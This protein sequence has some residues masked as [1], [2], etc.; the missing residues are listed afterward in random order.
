M[1]LIALDNNTYLTAALGYAK[2]GMVTKALTLLGKC[3]S[4]EGRINRIVLLLLRGDFSI[5]NSELATCI[6]QYGKTHN[7]C[8]DIHKIVSSYDS[9]SLAHVTLNMPV[10]PAKTK[11]NIDEEYI[12]VINQ[13]ELEPLS[14]IFE[15]EID[16]FEL[17][18]M[19]N[20][21]RMFDI[22]S[23]EYL[24]FLKYKAYLLYAEG[25]QDEAN[26]L[27]E[28]IL[29]SD[30]DDI[31]IL[32]WKIMVLSNVR[33]YDK[34]MNIA[35]KIYDKI[36]DISHLGYIA[37]CIREGCGNKDML[38]SVIDKIILNLEQCS[39]D[40]VVTLM[41]ICND[42]LVD[43]SLA[44]IFAK[45]LVENYQYFPIDSMRDA[46][47]AFVNHG[48]IDS[49]K[50]VTTALLSSVPDDVWALTVLKALPLI[51]TS[52]VR[53]YAMAMAPITVRAY[54]LPR[55]V[56]NTAVKAMANASAFDYNAMVLLRGVATHCKVL[57]RDSELTSALLEG[58]L[59]QIEHTILDESNISLWLEFVNS[60]LLWAL[61][62][63][64]IMVASMVRLIDYGY[65]GKLDISRGSSIY[66]IDT[67]MFAPVL[68][69]KYLTSVMCIVCLLDKVTAKKFA[70]YLAYYDQDNTD[71][72]F[73]TA[74][75]W[76]GFAGVKLGKG[77]QD[78]I[79]EILKWQNREKHT[80]D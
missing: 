61:Y 77:A 58:M 54:A 76:A 5:A 51:D 39:S 55:A 9:G 20:G 13:E 32:M 11:K 25:N 69:D 68:G 3:D 52:T 45:F 6:A 46:V 23:V 35:E 37:E 63:L 38:R 28:Q 30:S 21:H 56:T 34:A 60:G 47:W 24:N 17:A 15:E 48:D 27:I 73:N 42:Y 78:E 12:V 14:E 79:T 59:Y 1:A 18:E 26:K 49:A 80:S 4:Y 71:N 67:G 66:R 62:P 72:C 10:E 41:R 57:Y 74:Q 16:F 70:K 40:R 43:Y 31:E 65:S 44:C 7:V 36:D 33:E 64:D 53:T 50:S 8:P 22:H 19:L 75:L 2:D 29:D